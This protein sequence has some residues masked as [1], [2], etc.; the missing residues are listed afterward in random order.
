MDL[1]QLEQEGPENA[2]SVVKRMV[3]GVAE[4][5]ARMLAGAVMASL[6]WRSLMYRLRKAE[7]ENADMKECIGQA[8]QEWE[9]GGGSAAIIEALWP[10]EARDLDREEA[11][12]VDSR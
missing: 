4:G 12:G 5:D 10:P 9:D 7:R 1:D 11:D 2:L 3:P 6:N 8:V